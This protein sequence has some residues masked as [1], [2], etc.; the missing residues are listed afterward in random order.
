MKSDFIQPLLNWYEANARDLPWRRTDDAYRI[1]VS[2]IMLQQTRVAAVIPYYNRFLA[3][4]PTVAAL[5]AVE[6]EPLH[7]LWE[8]LGYYSRA[9]N[10]RLAAGQILERFGGGVPLRYADLITLPGIGD[11]TAGAVASIAGGEKVP[12][13]DGNVLRVM[14]RL[15]NDRRDVADPRTKQAVRQELLPLFAAL[16][17][18]TLSMKNPHLHQP[19]PLPG[20]LNSALMELGA[21]ICVPNGP[22][23]C[24]GCPLKSLCAA[25]EAGVCRELPVKHPKKARHILEK[26]VF[27]LW[28]ENGWLGFRRPVSGL[29]AGLW[30]LPE[31]PGLLEERAIAERLNAWGLSPT[32]ALLLYQRKHVFTHMEWRMQVCAAR[33]ASVGPLPE[34]WQIL[35]EQMTLPTAYRICL[36]SEKPSGSGQQG[37]LPL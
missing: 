12:A 7:K 10:L 1:W 34:G 37:R 29:L 24:E 31:E 3:A 35:T 16:P 30:Q 8:G 2:E 5:A 17:D 27:A 18:G 36:P 21:T 33:V 26:T 23:Q 6:E 20:L 28:A 19:A 25:Y 11:Y 9:N 14:A 22:P 4:L 15:Q 32:G 13:V